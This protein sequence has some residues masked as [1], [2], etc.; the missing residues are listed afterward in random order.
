LNLDVPGVN[1]AQRHVVALDKKL[2]RIAQRRDPLDQNRLATHKPHLH[3]TPPRTPTPTD[4]E[5]P[6]AL[7]RHKIAQALA[8]LTN[9]MKSMPMPS[10][11]TMPA[12][13][14]MS[15]AELLQMILIYNRILSW[16]FL[17]RIVTSVTYLT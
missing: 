10:S 15:L 8:D 9:A 14:R 3:E 12:K 13:H 17:E 16:T 5:D 7:P 11:F 2:D 1:A 6:G 4:P